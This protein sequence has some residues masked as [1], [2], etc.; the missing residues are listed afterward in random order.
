[1]G[2][3]LKP[4]DHVTWNTSQGVTKGRVVKK[5]TKRSKIKAHTV[6][7]SQDNPEYIVESDK[8]G[9]RAA[10]KRSALKKV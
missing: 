10:H 3:A 8:S 2:R 5:T 4:G 6:A 1:M 9:N 7:A